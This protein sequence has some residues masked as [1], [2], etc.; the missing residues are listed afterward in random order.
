MSAP[1]PTSEPAPHPELR[2]VADRLLAS[3]TFQ[4]SPRLKEFLA[5]VVK[6]ALENRAHEVNEYSIGVQVFGKPA[7]YNPNLDNIVRVTARQLRTRLSEYY[8]SEGAA[9]RWRLE[10]PKGSYLPVVHAWPPAEIETTGQPPGPPAWVWPVVTGLAVLTLAGW[11]CAAWL[12][13]NWQAAHPRNAFALA[14]ILTDKAHPATIVLDDPMLSMAWNQLGAQQSLDEFI[15]GRYLSDKRYDSPRGALVQEMLQGNYTVRVSTM[16][17][18][19]ELSRIAAANGVQIRVRQCRNLEVKD[20]ESGNFI[21]IGGV[22]ANPW[23]QAIQK[24]LA[25][26]HVVDPANRRRYFEP[27]APRDGEPQRFESAGTEGPGQKLYTRVASLKNPFGSGRVSL[28][29]GTSRDATEAA[30]RFALSPQSVEQVT[31]L[32]GA[33]PD[34]L[35]SFELILQ[36]S[37]I[38]GTPVAANVVAHRCGTK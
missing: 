36:T 14:A 5:F 27:R 29:G 30:G 26:E 15:A 38:G 23:V 16:I 4:R 18:S 24:N 1:S 33:P 35:S 17:L 37:A 3:T 19:E 32:C 31:K 21:F 10:I 12:F 25:F 22:G 13:N 20:L 11:A 9:D 28:L 2:A 34:R 7:D 8:S 6:C